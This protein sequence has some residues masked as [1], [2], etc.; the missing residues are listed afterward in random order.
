MCMNEDKEAGTVGCP[1]HYHLKCLLFY[2]LMPDLDCLMNEPWMSKICRQ[3]IRKVFDEILIWCVPK[4]LHN[5][6]LDWKVLRIIRLLN[7][8]I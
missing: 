6:N 2:D 7:T 1:C 5:N 3:I 8:R 4:I